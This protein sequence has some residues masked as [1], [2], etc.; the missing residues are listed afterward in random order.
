MYRGNGSRKDL[1]CEHRMGKKTT[2][3]HFVTLYFRWDVCGGGVLTVFGDV[4]RSLSKWRRGGEE[5]QREEEEE[6]QGQ[7]GGTRPPIAHPATLWH[8]H[9]SMSHQKWCGTPTHSSTHK[10]THT[11]PLSRLMH[12]AGHT[13]GTS[14]TLPRAHTSRATTV[15]VKLAGVCCFHSQKWGSGWGYTVSAPAVEGRVRRRRGGGGVEPENKGKGWGEGREGGWKESKEIINFSKHKSS[16][17]NTN[18]NIFQREVDLQIKK[19]HN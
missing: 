4:D 18:I 12:A 16:Q 17:N 13:P 7:G 6:D 11:R 9:L 19:S 15:C 1:R 8:T 10:T 3:S 14:Q 5:G 2:S